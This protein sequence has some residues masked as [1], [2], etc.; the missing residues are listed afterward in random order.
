MKRADAD[1]IIDAVARATQDAELAFEA[2]IAWEAHAPAAWRAT[3]RAD[4]MLQILAR[5]EKRRGV[6]ALYAC[7][8]S[9]EPE[10]TA[11]HLMLAQIED[12]LAGRSTIVD[13]D[14]IFAVVSDQLPFSDA[15]YHIGILINAPGTRQQH[16]AIS[17][18]EI[19]LGVSFYIRHPR[20]RPHVLFTR[21]IRESN[22]RPP[23]LAEL[24]R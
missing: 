3:T 2:A 6:A 22:P 24:T 19:C 18:A 23:T 7:A 14:A 11:Q 10:T 1:A 17:Q 16:S 9:F 20:R 4:G 5:A 12:W 13:K 8:S 21:M 15:L